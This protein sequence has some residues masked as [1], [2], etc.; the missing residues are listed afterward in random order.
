MNVIAALEA[1]AAKTNGSMAENMLDDVEESNKPRATTVVHE[2][3]KK[4]ETAKSRMTKRKRSSVGRRMFWAGVW[5]GGLTGM[6][7]FFGNA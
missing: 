6:I 2:E 1:V 5:V 3:N 4:A 7:G